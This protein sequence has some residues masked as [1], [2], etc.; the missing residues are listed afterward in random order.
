MCNKNREPIPQSA[1]P[2]VIVPLVLR[3]EDIINA[4]QLA[5][6]AL[7]P[8]PGGPGGQGGHA[9]DPTDDPYRQVRVLSAFPSEAASLGLAPAALVSALKEVGVH[10]VLAGSLATVL[11]DTGQLA[12]AAELSVRYRSLYCERDGRNLFRSLVLGKPTSK[13]KAAASPH[14]P[15]STADC[16]DGG[17]NVSAAPRR[18][19]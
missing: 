19:A 8:P 17:L 11:V 18:R 9:A 3:T 1:D 12:I 2:Q 10:K 6:A 7:G 4:H 15:L 14:S 13:P 5:L 16:S